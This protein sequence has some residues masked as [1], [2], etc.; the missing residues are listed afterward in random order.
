MTD[1]KR[2]LTAR[3]TQPFGTKKAAPAP[4]QPFGA[5]PRALPPDVERELSQGPAK[6]DAPDS[7]K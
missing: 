3:P 1:C 6:R 7:K 5:P 4:A 2:R